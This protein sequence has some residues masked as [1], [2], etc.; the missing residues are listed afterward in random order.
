M[1]DQKDRIQELEAALKKEREEN[2]ALKFGNGAGEKER[3]DAAQH[4]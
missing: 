1:Q 2:E 3:V 4:A